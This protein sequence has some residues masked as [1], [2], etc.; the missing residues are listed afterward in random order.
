MSR[1]YLKHPSIFIGSILLALVSITLVSLAQ[2][3]DSDGDG[4][5]DNV[6]NCINVANPDQKDSDHDGVGDVCDGDINKD[7]IVNAIDLSLL[8][9][10][11][12]KIIPNES[13]NNPDLNGD[14][15]V[16]ALDLALMRAR[17]GLRAGPSAIKLPPKGQVTPPVSSSSALFQLDRTLP[18]GSNGAAT[19]AFGTGVGTV[20]PAVIGGKDVSLRDDGVD[21]DEKGGDGIFSGFIKLDTTSIQS[22]GQSFLDRLQASPNSKKVVVQFSGHDVISQQPFDLASNTAQLVSAN[23][24]RTLQSGITL[25]PF[26]PVLPPL[27]VLP[28][29]A[30][31]TKALMVT[32]KS[33]VA[34]RTRTFDPCDV[35]NVGSQGNPNNVWSFKTLLTN[36]ANTGTTGI[37]AQTFV[38][39][40]LHQ[41]SVTGS[42]NTFSIPPRTSGGLSAFFP[43]WDGVNAATLNMDRLPFRLLAIVNRL[44]LGG[45]GY[46]V[47]SKA[48]EI[49][50]VFGLVSLNPKTGA[51]Q[52]PGSTAAA[53]QMTVIFEYGDTAASCETRQ[54]RAKQWINLSNSGF[55]AAFNSALQAITDD[56]TAPNAVVT[57]PNHSAINQIRTNE[58]VLAAPKW[59]L[60]E[61]TLNT[62]DP[63][64]PISFD[65]GPATIKQTP[66]PDSFRLGSATT[67]SFWQGNADKILCETHVVEN[68]PGVSPFLGSHADY[69]FGTA[70]DAP[71]VI[72]G[73][74]PICWKSNVSSGTPS[75]KG[76]VRHKFSLNT[77]DDCHSGETAT[78]FTHVKPASS[79]AGLSGFLTGINVSDPGGEPVVRHFNDLARR[80]QALEDAAQGC[81]FLPT[82]FSQKAVFSL[83][84]VH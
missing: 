21:P 18:D 56:V 28:A 51:C 35:D 19:F 30:D 25:T 59:Q 32:D 11:F 78:V 12:G 33:V 27:A 29:L 37:P 81:R 24:A 69:G 58:V 57:K 52:A 2:V 61:F 80:G 68:F 49:R 8:G 15:A 72:S 40:W 13:P 79:P 10:A 75:K 82:S 53:E 4:V 34:D 55:S 71:T 62:P 73:S 5:T 7:G 65:L 42:V 3:A 22:A 54:T 41:W 9:A 67:A 60:R 16:N 76:E 64:H 43:G 23:A 20:V 1:V 47:Q 46:G 84:S 44:D 74:L 83:T 45:G 77:C 38:N 48:G 70:W 26:L 39:N 14:G 31:P 63:A 17:F 6:D 66:D 50:F 36:M